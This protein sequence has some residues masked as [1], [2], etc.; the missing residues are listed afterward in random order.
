MEDKERQ[1]KIEKIQRDRYSQTAQGTEILHI[2]QCSNCKKNE[3][4]KDCAAFGLKP[5]VY[6][7]NEVDCPE[8]E[9]EE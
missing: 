3:G 8:R 9:P 7:S 1:K 6:R 5:E 4:P 2:P